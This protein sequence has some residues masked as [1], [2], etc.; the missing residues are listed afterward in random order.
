MANGYLTPSRRGSLTGSPFGGSSLF[1]LHRQVNRLFDDILGGDLSPGLSQGLSAGAGWPQLEIE[2]KDDQIRVVAELPG[3]K[4]DDIDLT[5]EDGMLT[6]SGEKR[7][8]RKEEGGYS[9]RS[10]G[11]FER[12]ISLPSNIDEDKCSADFRDG[13][14]T[15]TIPRSEEKARGRR[16]PLGSRRAGPHDRGAERPRAAPDAAGCRGTRPRPAGGG[17]AARE[18]AELTR[19]HSSEQALAGSTAGG[20]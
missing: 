15:I 1:D 9:E 13:M 2:Q 20:G 7:S 8:E 18:P 6:L 16:I 3:V 11:R 19:R 14:L 17:L 10:Y 12:R 4:E 5:V